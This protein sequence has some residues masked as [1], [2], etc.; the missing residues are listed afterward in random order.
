M[1]NTK[2]TLRGFSHTWPSDVDVLLVGPGGE[3]FIPLSDVGGSA[4]AVNLD[5]TLDDA[6][7]A[8]LSTS[9]LT[10]GSFRPTNSGTGDVFP[11]PAATAPY[12]SPA[13]AGTATFASAFGGT[14]PNGTWS[15][16]AIDDT[17]T[18]VGQITNGWELTFVTAD[19]SCAVVNAP[20]ISGAS[21][22]QPALWPPNH[23]MREVNVTYGTGTD[24][25]TCALS[26][27][28]SEAVNGTGDGDTGPDWQVVDARKVLLRAERAG[29]GPGR[30][31]TITI[32]CNNGA[33][34]SV[35]SV[36]VYVAHNI[37]S[38]DAGAAFRVGTPIGF[39]GSFWDVAGRRHTARWSF[40]NLST[41]G[42]VV[43]PSGSKSGSVTGSYTFAEPGVYRVAM[44]VTDDRNVTA[45]IT[46]AGDAEAIVVVYDPNGG[47]VLGG[48]WFASPAGKL[49]F[50]Y[51]SKYTNSKNP[52]GE[53]QFSVG[54]MSFDASSLDYL[55]IAGAR[56][57]VAGS[58]KLNGDGPYEFLLSMIDGDQP[59]G[60]GVD[61]V[62]VKVWHKVT[63]QV[64]Y[65]SQPGASD[66]AD[67]ATPVGAGS[68]VVIQK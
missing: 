48:G 19:P 46:N 49:T 60:G 66:A 15:L 55:T 5:I 59:G 36:P 44:N 51:N 40:D 18:D 53:A 16:Y 2:L 56:A 54:S 21:V 32:T 39:S 52:K 62:R 7:S 8:A 35:Q 24:C 29:N 47:Y 9:L 22:D 33:G 26:V 58:G 20:V 31:Y 13:T 12:L 63:G 43:E 28:S 67:P 38:P 1:V 14:N 42:S 65:D 45:S 4:D 27:T 23:S 61:R 57:Q 50:G 11:A 64:I 17:G 37:G 41:A 25:A 30:I 10:S 6:A 3:K 34:V 68:R